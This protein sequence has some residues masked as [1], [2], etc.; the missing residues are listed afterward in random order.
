MLPSDKKFITFRSFVQIN[1]F[2]VWLIYDVNWAFGM[3]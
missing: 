3:R 2:Y 1:S